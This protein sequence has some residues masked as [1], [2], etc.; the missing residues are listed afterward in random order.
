MARSIAEDSAFLPATDKNQ[1]LMREQ[2]RL[3]DN[4]MI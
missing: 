1:Q 2:K 3:G 4:G